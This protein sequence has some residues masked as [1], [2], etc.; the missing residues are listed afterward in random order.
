MVNCTVFNVQRATWISLTRIFIAI[1]ESGAEHVVSDTR[2]TVT[3][4]SAFRIREYRNRDFLQTYSNISGFCSK[5]KKPIKRECEK[6]KLFFWSNLLLHPIQ[7]LLPGS[8]REKSKQNQKSEKPFQSQWNEKQ[9]TSKC[10]KLFPFSGKQTGRRIASY[11]TGLSSLNNAVWIE[12]EYY[13]HQCNCWRLK[14]QKIWK[15]D[16]VEPMSLL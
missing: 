10:E 5:M 15:K 4:F 14:K 16:L 7:S 3:R 9:R 12:M 11:L 2:W 1:F 13:W 6:T 8:R